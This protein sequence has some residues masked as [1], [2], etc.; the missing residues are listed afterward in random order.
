[1]NNID[2]SSLDE[3]VNFLDRRVYIVAS[4]VYNPATRQSL[5]L[6]NMTDPCV[7]FICKV[8]DPNKDVISFTLVCLLFGSYGPL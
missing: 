5:A 6:I 8:D 2:G 4:Y 3:S 7:G 1:M